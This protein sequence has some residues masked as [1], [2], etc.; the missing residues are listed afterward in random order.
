VTLTRRI[1]WTSRISSPVR[2]TSE[3]GR[4][5]GSCGD[6]ADGGALRD[7]FGGGQLRYVRNVDVRMGRFT[8]LLIDEGYRQLIGVDLRLS[9][10]FLHRY[11]SDNCELFHLIAD[12]RERE[13]AQNIA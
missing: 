13:K 1:E 5:A 9:A 2:D 4:R 8:V 6:E 10:R 3:F 7:D 11:G 12:V